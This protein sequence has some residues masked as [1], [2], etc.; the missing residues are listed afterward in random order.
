MYKFW[1]IIVAFFAVFFVVDDSNYGEIIW[2]FIW[3]PIVSMLLSYYTLKFFA[4]LE[5]Q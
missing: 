2:M 4:W 1:T 3:V 5:D